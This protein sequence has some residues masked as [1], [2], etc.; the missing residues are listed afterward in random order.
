MRDE[1]EEFSGERYLPSVRGRLRTEHIHRYLF[2]TR[3]A[4]GRDVLDIACGEGY[5]S[6]TLGQVARSVVGVDIAADVVQSANK[7]YGSQ[8]VSFRHGDAEAIPVDDGSVDLVV[9]FETIEHIPRPLKML[10]EVRRALRHDGVLLVS[11]PDATAQDGLAH[12]D[13]PFH[14][15]EYTRAEFVGMLQQVFRHVA[16]I[17]QRFLHGSVMIHSHEDGDGGAGLE[18][19]ESSDGSAYKRTDGAIGDSYFIAIASDVEISAPAASVLSDLQDLRSL[20]DEFRYAVSTMHA[21]QAE[22]DGLRRDMERVLTALQNNTLADS[23]LSVGDSGLA[24]LLD[25]I[26]SN[27]I[28]RQLAQSHAEYM[29]RRIHDLAES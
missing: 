23:N 1:K 25:Q 12:M 9:S 5:G 19:F 20:E 6:Q 2:A 8:H 15:K 29:R 16:V 7:L 21:Y 17:E 28:A 27:D 3:F 24:A 26:R 4:V 10:A 14:V 22:L 11:T 13:N 18:H